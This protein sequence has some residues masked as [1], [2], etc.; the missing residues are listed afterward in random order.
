[1]NLRVSSTDADRSAAMIAG[2]AR[3]AEAD[4]LAGAVVTIDDTGVRVHRLPLS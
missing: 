1:V 3:I 4:L 2:V